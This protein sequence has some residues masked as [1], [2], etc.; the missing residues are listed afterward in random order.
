[1]KQET[2]KAEDYGLEVAKANELTGGLGVSI[3]E[4]ELLI[5]EFKEVSKLELTQENLPKFKDL[6]LRIVKNRTQGIDLWHKK[7]KEVSLR[8]GQFYDAVKR[9]ENQVN[10]SMEE[11]LMS[12]EKHFENLEN[13]RILK[14]QQER[15]SLLSE[16]I[17]DAHERSLSSMDEDVWNAY[18]ESKKKE[19]E[20]RITAEK[21]AEEERIATEKAEAEERQRIR[22]E[23][24]QLKKEAEERERVAKIEAEQREKI[25]AQRQAK[26]EAERKEREE[27]QR[28]EREAYEAKLKA[29][30]EE[31]ERI[32]REEKVKREKLEA[33]LKAK[34]EAER[35]AKEQEE[36]RIQF[37]LNKG[38]SDKVKD[39]KVD[40]IELKSKYTF[41]SKK[42]Q[43][44]YSD[45]GV[46]IEKVINHING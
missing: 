41:T 31:K 30:R 38:D 45:V 2:I 40:F 3:A 10:Q 6:R 21:K 12:A 26:E 44:M 8:L 24:E 9:M 5:K 13:E 16:F 4:R 34:I 17:E 20:D 37:Q 22:K 27:T 14:L 18:F 39:L 35:Q 15:V 43:K 25:E 19:H 29:E 1:M 36:A 42:N 28:K 23:N 46:F 11:K 32:E 7:G 33:E